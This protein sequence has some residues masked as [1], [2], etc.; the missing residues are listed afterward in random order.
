MAASLK[1]GSKR[2]TNRLVLV[3]GSVGS[4]RIPELH[5]IE[6]LAALV[7]NLD[8]LAIELLSCAQ[9]VGKDIPGAA[10]GLEAGIVQIGKV[11]ACLVWHNVVTIAQVGIRDL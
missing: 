7:G 4:E 1:V 5:D 8:K 10:D 2:P 3:N 9:L 11:H 6:H